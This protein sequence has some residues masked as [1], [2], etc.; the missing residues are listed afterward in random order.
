MA[1]AAPSATT[2]PQS[3]PRPASASGSCAW[4]PSLPPPPPH[5][6]AS[7][8]SGAP[9]SSR[10]VPAPPAADQAGLSPQ[11]PGRCTCP[12]CIRTDTRRSQGQLHA[13]GPH[14]HPDCDP[15]W[16]PC[17]PPP[18]PSAPRL[19]LLQARGAAPQR[20][21]TETL[22]P[23]PQGCLGQLQGSLDPSVLLALRHPG[24][25]PCGSRPQ[26]AGPRSQEAVDGRT[27]AGPGLPVCLH[28]PP[29]H[30]C[31]LHSTS[32]PPPA[33]CC[34][35]RRPDRRPRRLFPGPCVS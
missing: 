27:G 6:S 31:S 10:Y 29:T 34:C 26:V 20:S 3:P 25:R 16:A 22:L 11:P 8:P 30:P 5:P 1:A 23:A 24:S 32:L 35:C 9:T 19:I 12:L 7:S 33:P 14:L 18:L 28:P 13:G 4:R 2:R 17:R 15:P 21:H